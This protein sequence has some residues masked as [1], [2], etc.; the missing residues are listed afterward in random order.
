MKERINKTLSALGSA[1]REG[2]LDRNPWDEEFL[3][4]ILQQVERRTLSQSQVHVLERLEK[5]YDPENLRAE[6]EWKRN[7]STLITDP[8]K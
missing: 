5:K 3:E 7:Y 1:L 6:A 2:R 8:S 4:S